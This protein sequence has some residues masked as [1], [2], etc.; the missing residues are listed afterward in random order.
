VVALTRDIAIQYAAKGIRANAILPGYLNTPMLAASL[1]QT[2][3][4]DV[5]EMIR[6]RDDLCPTG[7]QGESWDVA[8]AALFLASGEAKYITGTTMVV[9]GGITATL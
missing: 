3:G 1:A 2:F 6:K 7:K 9:D 4:G 8:Y 5:D